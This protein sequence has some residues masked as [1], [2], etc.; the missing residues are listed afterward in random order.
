MWNRARER[1]WN[2]IRD[3][4]WNEILVC[5]MEQ[6]TDYGTESEIVYEIRYQQ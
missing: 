1:L 6:G 5:G 4:A 2:G 3:S